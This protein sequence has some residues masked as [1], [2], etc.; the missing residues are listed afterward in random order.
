MSAKVSERLNDGQ[1]NQRGARILDVVLRNPMRIVRFASA[2]VGSLT[3]RSVAVVNAMN[4]KNMNA[5]EL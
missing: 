1:E 3:G 5:A 4:R 2:D